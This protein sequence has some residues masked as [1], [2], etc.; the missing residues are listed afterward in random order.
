MNFTV[1]RDELLKPLVLVSGAIE[2]KHTLPILSNVLIEVNQGKLSL[3]GTDLEVEM[4]ASSVMAEPAPDFRTTV[5][6]KKLLDIVKSL[7]D[8]VQINVQMEGDNLIL[9]AGKSRFSLSTLNADEYPNLDSW[10][11]V[12]DFTS[13]QKPISRFD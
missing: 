7:P 4:V 5:P 11:A 3:T 10:D 8:G 1:V 2:R 12:S 6:A 13:Q 9:R